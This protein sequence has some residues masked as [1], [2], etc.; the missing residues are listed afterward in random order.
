MNP[1]RWPERRSQGIIYQRYK[2]F[3]L[4]FRCGTARRDARVPLPVPLFGRKGP[5]GARAVTMAN[6]RFTTPPYLR[7]ERYDEACLPT[8]RR[9]GC[10]P[11]QGAD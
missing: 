4:S 2:K 1:V 9:T 6:S 7:Q 5:A 10:G 3:R 11:A 8:Q